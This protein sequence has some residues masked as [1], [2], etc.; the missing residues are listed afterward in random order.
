MIT[1]KSFIE[2]VHK[3]EHYLVSLSVNWLSHGRLRYQAGQACWM[4]KYFQPM[5]IRLLG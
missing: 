1:N 3:Y 4:A 5:P 2:K